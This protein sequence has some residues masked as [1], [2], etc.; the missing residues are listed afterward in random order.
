MVLWRSPSQ[1][2]PAV[3][4]VLHDCLLCYIHRW[5]IIKIRN[6]ERDGGSSLSAKTL[7]LSISLILTTPSTAFYHPILPFIILSALL[8]II[9]LFSS[10]L[11]FVFFYHQPHRLT[12][13]FSHSSYLLQLLPF[14]PSSVTISVSPNR[15]SVLVPSPQ[16]L[17]LFSLAFFLVL[18][19]T[20]SVPATV[21]VA[22]SC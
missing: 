3:V 12:F 21:M 1:G 14:C 17:E 2:I 15:I 19:V 20:V 16:S 11:R 10:I 8:L 18:S 9:H 7:G 22:C 13:K 4:D 5:E 6:F